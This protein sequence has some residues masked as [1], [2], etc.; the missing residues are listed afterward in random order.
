MQLRTMRI[1]FNGQQQY[2]VR[3]DYKGKNAFPGTR[4]FGCMRAFDTGMISLSVRDY[5][6]EDGSV[7]SKVDIAEKPY[8][9]LLNDNFGIWD[10]YLFI[11]PND[12]YSADR[13]EDFSMAIVSDGEVSCWLGNERIIDPDLEELAKILQADESY[14]EVSDATWA[15]VVQRNKHGEAESRIEI[16]TKES[17]FKKLCESME[18]YLTDTGLARFDDILNLVSE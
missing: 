12:S 1:P 8:S 18:Q 5:I 10:S 16:R 7:G 9:D 2:R 11:T 6:R 17:N 4:C 3:A 13:R 14:Y 15:V